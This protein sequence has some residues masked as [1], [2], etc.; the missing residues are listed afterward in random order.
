MSD[1]VDNLVQLDK[2]RQEWVRL[3]AEYTKAMVEAEILAVERDGKKEKVL[4]LRAMADQAERMIHQ[5]R[6]LDLQAE[7]RRALWARQARAAE[8]LL[9]GDR[10]ADPRDEWR[11][12]AFF[13]RPALMEALYQRTDSMTVGRDDFYGVIPDYSIFPSRPSGIYAMLKTYRLVPKLGSAPHEMLVVLYQQAADLAATEATAIEA[14]LEAARKGR[15]DEW[16]RTIRT[17]IDSVK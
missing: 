10:L 12:F 17:L 4:A 2:V 9:R 7:S 13:M 14:K 15:V 3:E 6:R 5:S 11:G 1:A 8:R 16:D